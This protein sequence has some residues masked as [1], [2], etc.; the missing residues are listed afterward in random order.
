MSNPSKKVNHEVSG[1]WRNDTTNNFR[2]PTYAAGVH[3][4]SKH[5]GHLLQTLRPP[6]PNT[7]ATYSKHL[8]N[9]LQTLRPPTP[10]TQ[11]TYSK[12]LGHP[13][14]IPRPPTP[15]TQATYPNLGHQLQTPRP[16]IG[17]PVPSKELCVRDEA[18]FSNHP[19]VIFVNNIEGTLC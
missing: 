13:L 17:A 19:C 7:Q 3:T 6:T 9:L 4:Y 5:P 2:S 18:T 1:D 16:P 15:N 12:H 14:Q 10:N 8:G 11:A